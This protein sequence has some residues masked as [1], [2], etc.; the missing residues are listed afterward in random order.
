M[1]PRNNLNVWGSQKPSG[2]LTA[3]PKK[4]TL[5]EEGPKFR[6]TASMVFESTTTQTVHVTE[7][8]ETGLVD[9]SESMTRTLVRMPSEDDAPMD[10][11]QQKNPNGTREDDL[12]KAV[13][14]LP[15]D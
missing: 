10:G 1:F 5:L 9:S 15:S 14:T 8:L 4:T 13:F 6:E 11:A 2:Q 3:E 12:F 7:Y